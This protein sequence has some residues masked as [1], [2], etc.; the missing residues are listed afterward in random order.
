MLRQLLKL[1]CTPRSALLLK[2]LLPKKLWQRTVIQQDAPNLSEILSVSAVA[3]IHPRR[4][5]RMS[6]ADEVDAATAVVVVAL[7]VGA[8]VAVAA[9]VGASAVELAD[10]HTTP[11][12]PAQMPLP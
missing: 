5:L 1:S 2:W 6:A 10:D 7:A 12:A 8:V 3:P 9:V 11:S 4:P